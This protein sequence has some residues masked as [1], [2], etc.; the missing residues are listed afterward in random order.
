ML[1][2]KN[3]IRASI[4]FDRSVQSK[5]WLHH[6]YLHT[7]GYMKLVISH[8]FIS[9]TISLVYE[10]T[11]T[12]TDIKCRCSKWLRK[13]DECDYSHNATVASMQIVSR[14]SS[15][16]KNSVALFSPTAASQNL[17]TR[18]SLLLET[19]VA[20]DDSLPYHLSKPCKR[21]DSLKKA[22]E[23][24]QMFRNMASESRHTLLG[25]TSVKRTKDSSGSIGISPDTMRARPAS[26]RHLPE[27]R[28]QLDLGSWLCKRSLEYFSC[29]M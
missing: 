19:T 28:R 4:T 15:Y 7:S 23:N 16:K 8:F 2:Q 9:G 1:T 17:A 22:V 29:I 10:S 18:I 27:T 5:F 11:V 14:R 25:S 12:Y 3:Q 24:L 13:N 26:K 20:A 21:F 6:D